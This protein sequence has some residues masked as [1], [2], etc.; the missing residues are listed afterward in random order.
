MNDK[1]LIKKPPTFLTCL[2]TDTGKRSVFTEEHFD[3]ARLVFEP[4]RR[5]SILLLL[6]LRR[7]DA[8]RSL[9]S[10][11]RSVRIDGGEVE[12]GLEDR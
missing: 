4:T 9:I 6:P 12:V 3:L 2:E 5:I 8:N 1:A 11:K 10:A 7:F